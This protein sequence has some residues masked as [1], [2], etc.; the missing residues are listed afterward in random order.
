MSQRSSRLASRELSTSV[1]EVASAPEVVARKPR[2]KSKDA[3]K[4][5]SKAAKKSPSKIRSKSKSKSP[6]RAKSPSRAKKAAAKQSSSPAPEK[7]TRGAKLYTKKDLV[8]DITPQETELPKKRTLR[9]SSS[10]SSMTELKAAKK[11]EL[12]A[13]PE[14]PAQTSCCQKMKGLLFNF[15]PIRY[16]P[17]TA[18]PINCGYIKANKCMIMR[19]LIASFLLIALLAM[20]NYYETIAPAVSDQAQ[21]LINSVNSGVASVKS[22]LVGLKNRFVWVALV[23]A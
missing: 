11:T 21:I 19:I 18:C 5:A 20:F 1:T 22:S 10:R 8:Q 14:A 16:C 2:S 12:E 17:M 23:E 3:V 4:A 9:S 15:C 6:A 7:P 13:T